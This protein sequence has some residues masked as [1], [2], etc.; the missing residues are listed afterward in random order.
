[1]R[2]E[3]AGMAYQNEARTQVLDKIDRLLTEFAEG[4]VSREQ[5]HAIYEHYNS[6]LM[7]IEQLSSAGGGADGTPHGETIAIRQ[8]HMGKALGLI[9]YHNK[10]G[11]YVDTLGDFDL[12]P[13]VLSPTL[14]DFS[15]LMES[16]QLIDRR[17]L[18]LPDHRWLLF[19][20][21]RYTSV[22]TLFHHEPSPL[23]IREIERLHHDFE[24]AN[25]AVL[26]T[27]QTIHAGSLVY[28]F[29]VFLQSKIGKP[30][31]N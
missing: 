8:K 31:R 29:L 23:Q 18:K 19:A 14:N 6:Q 12:P 1:M 15:L 2:A 20:A 13:S 27:T 26:K 9:I 28:P 17:V 10:S 25:Q 11:I 22:V 5:F 21:G 16:G 30:Q 4:K 3:E 24:S 7:L